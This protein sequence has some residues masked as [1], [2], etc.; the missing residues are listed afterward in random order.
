MLL[1]LTTSIAFAEVIEGTLYQSDAELVNELIEFNGV[2]DGRVKIVDAAGLI[3]FAVEFSGEYFSW[4]SQSDIE[5]VASTFAAVGA[6]SSITSWSSDFAICLFEDETLIMSTEDCLTAV[7][8]SEQGYSD[9]YIGTFMM[10]N[11]LMGLRSEA[12]DVFDF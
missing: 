6:V 9:T 4:E 1:I 2:Y 3:V 12:S 5:R 8:L 11:I 7:S 10:N